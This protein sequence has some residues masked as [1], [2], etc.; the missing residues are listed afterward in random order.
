MTGTEIGNGSFPNG[1]STGF[2]DSIGGTADGIIGVGKEGLIDSN[3][4]RP[5][6]QI[7]YSERKKRQPRIS[8][9]KVKSKGLDRDIVRRIV[10]SHIN[11]VRSCYNK[12]LTKNPHLEGRVLV[13]FTILSNGKVSSAVIQENTLKNSDLASCIQ[14]AIKRWRFPTSK[15][16]SI[17]SY[18]FSLRSS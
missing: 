3:F 13:Q 4:N 8:V 10:R 6:G 7:T 18:P 5:G 2:V 15:G 16:I 12:A 14:K 17:V 11:E 1:L 9:G